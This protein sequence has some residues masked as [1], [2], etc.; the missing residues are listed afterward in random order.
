MA[1]LNPEILRG[2][3]ETWCSKRLAASQWVD[4]P[5]S[6]FDGPI[7]SSPWEIIRYRGNPP[8]VYVE[9]RSEG[10]QQLSMYSQQGQFI[11]PNSDPQFEGLAQSL[12]SQRR[13]TA[14]PDHP[15]TRSDQSIPT[16]SQQ[17]SSF[18]QGTQQRGSAG[19][20]YTR[21]SSSLTSTA[22]QIPLPPSANDLYRRGWDLV[23]GT[24]EDA[25]VTSIF[26]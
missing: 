3:I 15:V 17:Q 16:P 6:Y 5:G 19:R 11:I 12:F 24:Q 21:I 18:E 8:P 25:V 23:F 20:W 10:W 9:P 2:E 7:S 14:N 26:P 1:L 4:V 13:Y 22:V